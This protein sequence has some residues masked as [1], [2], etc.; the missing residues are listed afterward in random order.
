RLGAG[1]RR[2]RDREPDR[3]AA[4][5]RAAARAW[6]RAGGRGRGARSRRRARAGHVAY[7]GSGR[8]VR[9]G[10]VRHRGKGTIGVDGGLNGAYGEGDGVRV[11]SRFALSV[12]QRLLGLRLYRLAGAFASPP[13]PA[14][15]SPPRD[16]STRSRGDTS[17]TQMTA[18]ILET[19]AA[20]SATCEC[21]DP[22]PVQ[23]AARKGAAVTICQ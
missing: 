14:R 23:R 9:H 5:D 11:R 12:L 8:D 4:L 2:P 10:R 15:P 3:H 6:A 1:H 13:P 19:A 18:K 16:S 21:A 22:I 7:P 17:M 20:T